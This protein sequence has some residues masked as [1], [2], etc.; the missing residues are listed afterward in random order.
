[1]FIQITLRIRIIRCTE[2][3]VVRP[4]ITFQTKQVLV[5]IINISSLETCNL[6]VIRVCTLS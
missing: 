6:V 4:W 1:M 3:K 5:I 2:A